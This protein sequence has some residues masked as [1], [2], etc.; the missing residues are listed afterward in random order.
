MAEGLGY[1]IS[2]DGDMK[3]SNAD[4]EVTYKDGEY[5]L[6]DG[7][8]ISKQMGAIRVSYTSLV[9]VAALAKALEATTTWDG[10]LYQVTLQT[11]R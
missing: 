2:W 1:S 3:I 9:P 5:F 6:D 11:Q 7:T 10:A 8:S 4:K